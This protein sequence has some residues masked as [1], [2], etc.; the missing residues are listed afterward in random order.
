MKMIFVYE[1]LVVRKLRDGHELRDLVTVERLLSGRKIGRP[2]ST[3]QYELWEK[4][5]QK[6]QIRVDRD[7]ESANRLFHSSVK[8]RPC[9]LDIPGGQDRRMHTVKYRSDNPEETLNGQ[10][11]LPTS[12][13]QRRVMASYIGAK[14]IGVSANYAGSKFR[15]VAANFQRCQEYD[16]R[17]NKGWH[18][19]NVLTLYLC[20]VNVVTYQLHPALR[21]N[22]AAPHRHPAALRRNNEIVLRLCWMM[23]RVRQFTDEHIGS[24]TSSTCHINWI[25]SVIQKLIHNWGKTKLMQSWYTTLYQVVSQL[26]IN[27]VTTLQQL[28]INSVVNQL[29]INFYDE[30]TQTWYR[31]DTK[32]MHSWYKV[33]I[34]FV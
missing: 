6:R 31:N 4:L 10:H 28:C 11:P 13:K 9:L 21:R 25:T 3:V 26:C 12:I 18:R 2:D 23:R 20:W 22:N 29:C 30:L 5:L 34:N 19:W 16:Q 7:S 1:T 8:N 33:C 24:T 27:F 17:R 15:F 32:M 14:H